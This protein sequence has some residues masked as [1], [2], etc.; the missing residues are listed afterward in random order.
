[1]LNGR[2]KKSRAIRSS[3]CGWKGEGYDAITPET[4]VHEGVLLLMPSRGGREKSCSMWKG[5]LRDQG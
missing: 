2:R 4:S 5:A 1:M 3:L